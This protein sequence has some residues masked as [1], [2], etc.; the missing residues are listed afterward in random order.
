MEIA[1]M[2][3]VFIALCVIEVPIAYALILPSM[4]VMLI[5]GISLNQIPI[6]VFR[7]L[8]SFTLLAVPFFLLAGDLMNS[9]KLTDKLIDLC[10]NI[11]GHIKG[12]LAHVNVLVSMI[13]A[14]ISGSSVADTAGI[15]A[16]LIPAMKKDGYGADFSVA[17]TAISS[18][19]GNIIPPSILMVIYGSMGDVSVGALFLGGVIPGVLI[20]LT[21]FIGSYYLSKKRDYPSKPRAT[22]KQLTSSVLVSIPALIMPLIIIGGV[23]SGKFT[24][25]EAGVIAVFYTLF[26]MA[27]ARNIKLKTLINIVGDSAKFLGTT[28]FCVAGSTVFAW[29]LGYFNANEVITSVLAPFAHMPIA[30]ALVLVVILLVVGMFISPLAGIIAFYPII[31]SVG[32]AAQLSPVVLGVVVVMTMSLG[33][34]TPPYGICLLIASRIGE[35]KPMLAFKE[36]LPFVILFFLVIILVIVFPQIILFV[37]NL[38]GL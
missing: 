5:K 37:P 7:G 34:V 17:I 28:I 13:F 32:S 14:G 11:C 2:F 22:A 24:A 6:L 38:F 27:V 31:S 18:T 16:V 33:L 36:A 26:V 12:G 21:Q 25:T 19:M 4:L 35:V 29:C 20:G 8:D 9:S 15:G 3:S 1:I 30:I 10:N 23:T